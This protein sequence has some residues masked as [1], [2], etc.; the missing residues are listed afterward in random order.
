MNYS[1]IKYG[2]MLN[3]RGIR[4]SLFLTGCSHKCEGCF[5]PVTWNQT[6]GD[7]FTEKTADDIFQYFY[8]YEGMLTGLSLLGGDPTFHSNI[9]PLKKFIKIFKEKF[10]KKDIWIWS[11]YTWEEISNDSSVYSLVS[12]CDVLIDGKFHLKEKDSSLKWRG[13]LNQRVID[14]QKTIREKNIS[15][16]I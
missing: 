6:L 4:V 8:K 1:G 10:P 12:L 13:S 9:E 14:I 16:V 5:N 3:G 2:D 11:G 7:S 15:F